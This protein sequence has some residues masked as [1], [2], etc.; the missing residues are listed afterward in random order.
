MKG[1]DYE[2]LIAAKELLEEQDS[3]K[4]PCYIHI[5]ARGILRYKDMEPT[6]ENLERAQKYIDENSEDGVFKADLT[7]EA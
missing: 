4:G 2:K 7:E 6:E 3:I 1:L 5:T